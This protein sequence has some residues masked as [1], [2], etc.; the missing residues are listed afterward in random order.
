MYG[1]HEKLSVALLVLKGT[2][3]IG[4]VYSSLASWLF[5]VPIPSFFQRLLNWFCYHS[6]TPR[7]DLTKRFLRVDE[8]VFSS[9]T[10]AASDNLSQSLLVLLLLTSHSS[11]TT[12][13]WSAV[14]ATQCLF[15]LGEFS[16]NR[17]KCYWGFQNPKCQTTYLLRPLAC[18]GQSITIRFDKT[19]VAY[20]RR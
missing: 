2:V 13:D 3:R 4:K 7:A 8:T 6:P 11:S 17:E 1:F 10:V 19:I 5:F 9:N 18:K 16:D 20:S 15:C 12:G 14:P